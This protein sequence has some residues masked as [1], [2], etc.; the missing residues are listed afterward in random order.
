MTETPESNERRELLGHPGARQYPAPDTH[1]HPEPPRRNFFKKFLALVVGGGLR[2]LTDCIA[3][4][5]G[6]IGQPLLLRSQLAACIVAGG[7]GCGARRL[8]GQAA[9]GVGNLLRLELQIAHRA[10]ALL[11]PRALHALLEAAHLLGRFG[12]ARARLLRILPP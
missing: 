6:P 11:G 8:V 5:R 10:L 7:A 9:F 12:S 1:G 4:P 3:Q 2:Q